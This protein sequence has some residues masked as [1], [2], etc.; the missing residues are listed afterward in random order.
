MGRRVKFALGALALLAGAVTGVMPQMAGAQVPASPPGKALPSA[1]Q[2]KLAEVA[3][4]VA[5]KRVADLSTLSNDVVHVDR[6][7]RVELAFHA[8]RRVGTVEE[9]SLKSLG[10]VGVFSSPAIGV[11]Q[12]FVP[13]A[14]VAAA[15][16]LP[17]VAAVTA[18]GYGTVDVG[19]VTS[20]GVAFHRA[21]LAQTAGI[22]GAGIN[23]G[24]ISD[25]VTNLAA[26]QALG[27]LPAGVNVLAVGAGDE[28]TAML[29]IVQDMAPSAGLI[30]NASGGGVANHVNALNNLVA[31]GANVITEDIAFDAEPAFQVGSA[32]QTAENIAAGGVSVHSSAGNQGARHAARVVANG[33]GQR[34]DNTANVP[35]GCANQPDNVVDIDPGAGTAFDVTVATT[36]PPAA[37]NTLTVTLQWSE[38]RA[39]F[40]TAGRGGFTDLNLYVMNA[41]LTQ[42]LGQSTAVQANGTGDTLEQVSVVLPQGSAAKI[43]VDVQTASTT[44]PTIDLRWRNGVAVDTTTRA[45]SLNPDSNYTGQA[46]S[47]AALNANSGNLEAFSSA[48]PVMLGLTRICPGLA[49]GPCGAGVAGGGIASTA[50]PTWAAAD[51]VTVTGVGG[52]GSPFFG[53]SASAPHAAACDALVRQGEVGITVAQVTQRLRATAIDVAPAGIDNITGAGRLDCLAAAVN[54]NLSITKS[55]SPDPVATGG[56]LTYTLSVTNNGPETAPVVTVV[57]TLPAGVTYVSDSLVAPDDCTVA[58]ATITCTLNNLL[59]GQTRNFTITTSVSPGATPGGVL[60][61]NARVSGSFDSVPGNNTTTASTTAKTQPTISTVATSAIGFTAANPPLITDTA[62]LGNGTAPTGTLTF[63]AFIPGNLTCAGAAA[64]TSVKAVA[65]NGNYVSDPFL[66][67]A[68]GVYRWTVVYSGDGANLPVTSPCNAPNETSTVTSICSAPPAPGTLPGNNIVIAAPGLTTFGTAG[69]DV[70]YG[71]AGADRIAGLGGD[72]IIFSGD[73]LDHISA[74]DGKDT[75]C[76]GDGPDQLSGGPGDDLLVG[77]PGNDDL[78]GGTGND[79]LIGGTGIDR[80]TGSEDTDTCT[81][82]TDPASQTL[83]C[84]VIV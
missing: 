42:C 60:V 39:I 80:L 69:N 13:S 38:P 14:K 81:P 15:S 48:G 54:A 37:N 4:A 36:N 21:D 53:T 77:G 58:G 20:E 16:A 55:D 82:G 19:S 28:G 63:R 40:P 9:Q 33:N 72:D 50:G 51:G 32:A 31:N 83:F 35:A 68:E 62:T 67:A 5:A 6:D 8:P 84:E 43:V 47:A 61:N 73:G 11:V 17:W 71:T 74:G 3:G 46:T 22:N 64:F 29:E 45:A 56:A 27:D 70:I 66:A 59:S 1:V 52:F 41:A 2:Q 23:V 24:V 75:L 7:G 44:A 65:G 76:G 26:S 57:D 79:R 18:P 30:F 10:A 12:G 49:A 34:P 25:G 78:A